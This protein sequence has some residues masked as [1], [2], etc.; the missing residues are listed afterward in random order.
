MLPWR[1]KKAD[2]LEPLNSRA[3]MDGALRLEAES[4]MARM[5]FKGFTLGGGTRNHS[6]PQEARWWLGLSL[7]L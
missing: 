1:S 3:M 7:Y 2:M 6:G 5:V 4:T